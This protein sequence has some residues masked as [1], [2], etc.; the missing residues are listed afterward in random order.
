MSTGG[1]LDAVEGLRSGGFVRFVAVELVPDVVA[2]GGFVTG[3]GMAKLGD[4]NVSAHS[5]GANLAE[6]GADA[7][8]VGK[9]V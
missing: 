4:L 5:S 2:A 8:P 9:A 7:V 1:T 6:C 3:G